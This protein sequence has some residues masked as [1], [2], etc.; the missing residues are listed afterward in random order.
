[1][2]LPQ[3]QR[4]YLTAFRVSQISHR[5]TDVLVIGSGVAGNSAA[6]A[7]SGQAGLEVLLLSKAE[8]EECSTYYAQGGVAAV[9]APEENEDSLDSHIEDTIVA[10]CGLADRD[11]VRMVVEEGVKRVEELIEWGARFDEQGGRIHFTTEGGHSRPRILH[12]GDTT[13]REIER[14]LLIE[15]AK[16]PQIL[17]LRDTYA[18]DLITRDGECR[19]AL[20]H[21]PSGDLQAIW[22][23]RTILATGGAGRIFRETT[24][25][26]VTTGDGL[27]MGLRAGAVFR[28]PEFIQF[29]PT[30]LYVAGADRFLIT[31]A[32]RGEG[33]KLI[34]KDGQRFM[35]RFDPRGELAPRDTVARGIMR[36]MKELGDNKVFLD[37]SGIPRERI[38]ERFPRVREFCLGFGIDILNEPIPVR[39]SAH[40]TV[41]GLRA[42]KEGR[43]DLPGLFAAGEVASSGL[44]GANRLGSNSLLEGLV[45]GT[46]AGRCAARE[47][48]RIPGPPVPF[49]PAADEVWAG[50]ISGKDHLDLPDLRMS[51]QSEMWRRV[52]LER[53]G[54]GV[55]LAWR[56][57]E[58]WVPYVLGASFTKPAGWTLQNM[59]MTGCAIAVGALKREETRGVHFRTD[60]PERDDARWAR[61]QDQRLADLLP[62]ED[63]PEKH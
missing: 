24:N 37:L 60:F 44:H 47:A 38:L 22:A 33:G 30:T 4:R 21:R 12:S 18:I 20:V 8:L 39:P 43:T 49:E 6:I 25:P 58:E 3:L 34:D 55:R 27:A 48:S 2:K 63:P 62:P 11:V 16:H 36:R 9:L 50:D 32:V 54:E 14:T 29:H 17:T 19:G 59:I 56:Q 5:F 51:L 15:L 23:K 28:D 53:A 1:M 57:I 61:H 41:G 7:A 42:D 10:A 13:G 46:R 40:Y 31:E 26:A 45:F 35:H 52:G